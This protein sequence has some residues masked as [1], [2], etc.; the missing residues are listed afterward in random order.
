MVKARQ[1]TDLLG[2]NLE[3]QVYVIL[4]MS[5]RNGS[6][7][8]SSHQDWPRHGKQNGL[9]VKLRRGTWRKQ[10]VSSCSGPVSRSD[11]GWTWSR[12]WRGMMAGGKKRRG[13]S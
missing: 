12:G 11:I 2:G 7:V 1:G 13:D 6:S 9:G 5:L 3:F 8:K 4:D 10:I